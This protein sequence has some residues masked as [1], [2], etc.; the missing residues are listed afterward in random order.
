MRDIYRNPL[1]RIGLAAIL[2]LGLAA[3]KANSEPKP[4]KS[5]VSYPSWLAGNLATGICTNLVA[6]WS[7]ED[8]SSAE[9]YVKLNG[10]PTA[11]CPNPV[12]EIAVVCDPAIINSGTLDGKFVVRFADK[13]VPSH[14]C[15]DNFATTQPPH[16]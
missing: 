7:E 15:K 11:N 4:E 13:A 1:V 14:D 8:R 9:K 5:K 12:T 10:Q 3:C 2:G 16:N 6:I